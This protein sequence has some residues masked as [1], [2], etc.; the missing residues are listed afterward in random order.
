MAV[1][2]GT[3]KDLSGAY[4]ARIVR[5]YR[6]DTGVLAAETTSDGTTGGF[7]LPVPAN[8]KYT[9]VRED[10]IYDPYCS[11]LLHMDGANAGTVFSE[12]T[13]KVVTRVG[14][15]ITST[16]Y[17]KFGA[18]SALLNGTT[19]CLTVPSSTDLL[20][21]S[22]DFTLEAFIR[23]TALPGVGVT[24][25]ILSKYDSSGTARSY[26]VDLSNAS[27]T[28]Q[29]TVA[30]SSAGTAADLVM[31]LNY[32]CSLVSFT[33]IEVCRYGTTIYV[34]A[35]G[36]LLGTA[37]YSASLYANSATAFT[38][39]ARSNSIGFFPGYIDEVR[40]SKGLARHTSDFSAAPIV[41]PLSRLVSYG[42]NAL[43]FDDVVPV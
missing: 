24:E 30:L 43:I 18:T 32:T 29:I 19:D 25:T 15:A 28:P 20:F 8:Y 7:S 36:T 40:V 42:G 33:H 9:V 4:A 39:G 14:S 2:S 5:A 11:A 6:K 22:G 26:A 27:G 16:T 21:G 3:V 17:A 13:G 23:P 10:A 35:N 37:S 41:S 12:E 34:F 31:L 1:I 38:I